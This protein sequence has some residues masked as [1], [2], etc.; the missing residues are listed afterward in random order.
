MTIL[1]ITKED[2]I[3]LM[4]KNEDVADSGKNTK[5]YLTK[6]GKAVMPT[7]IQKEFQDPVTIRSFFIYTP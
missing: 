3:P 1:R 7:M 2:V 6:V 5:K 4:T